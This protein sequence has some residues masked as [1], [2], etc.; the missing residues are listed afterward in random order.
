VKRPLLFDLEALV[1]WAADE[2]P[3]AVVKAVTEGS[4]VYVS[5]VT[6]WEF[7]LKDSTGRYRFGITYDQL[8]LTMKHLRAQLLQISEEHLRRLKTMAVLNDH[9]DPFDR[10]LIAQALEEDLILVGADR[11]FPAYQKAFSLKL[12]WKS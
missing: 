11:K 9:H 1:K 8:F 5:I 2:T 4:K 12:L 3:P 7:I 10:L 6:P